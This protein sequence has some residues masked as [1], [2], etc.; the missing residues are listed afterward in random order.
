MAV[1]DSGVVVFPAVVS[2][3]AVVV[4]G[5]AVVALTVVAVVVA[6]VVATATGDPVPT[7]GTSV[8]ADVWRKESAFGAK[9]PPPSMHF[10]QSFCHVQQPAAPRAV[11]ARLHALAH[12][13]SV[14]L[15]R[16]VPPR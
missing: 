7:P 12:V 9:L 16:Y 15:L 8:H 6:V 13:P 5:F 14:S 10:F 2:G 11:A 4:S 1:V 3:F